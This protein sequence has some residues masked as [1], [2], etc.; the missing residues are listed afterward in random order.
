MNELT[1]LDAARQ[2][3]RITEQA[4]AWYI[5]QQ[6]PLSERQRTA[7]LD[8]LRAS[9]LHVAEYF[10]IAQM[11][12][13][14]KAAAALE[15]LSADELA[16]QARHSNPIV[17]FPRVGKAEPGTRNPQPARRSHIGLALGGVAGMAAAIAAAWL[18]L[19][20]RHAV[21]VQTVAQASVQSYAGNAAGVRA[22]TLSDGTLIQLDRDSR[23]EVRFDAHQ[24]RIAVLRGHVLFDIG[25]DRVRPMLVDVGGH[26]L[27]DIGTIFDVRRDAAGDTLTVI[28][29]RVRVLKAQTPP[30]KGDE[31]PPPGDSVADL[32]AGQQIDLD[33][34]GTSRIHTVQAAQA[35]AWLP[36]E[37]SF[38]HETIGNVA[39]RFNA[40]TSKPL[41]IEDAGIAGQRISGIFHANNP[42]AFVAYLAT[43]PDVRVIDAGDRIRV[44][45]VSHETNTKAGQL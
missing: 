4:A 34:S 1:Q 11:H 41:A 43:L 17:M 3:R 9:P 30:A 23:I 16:E 31:L 29:G 10:A 28:S 39:R 19:A 40:Y 45:S 37:I 32:T 35:T 15:K 7:F 14:V 25:K 27:Q 20:P 18:G 42:Q 24:R 36:S 21:P 22:L 5:E 44:V 12:G 33:V 13:D 26:V 8:W 6:E 2:A 38:Q